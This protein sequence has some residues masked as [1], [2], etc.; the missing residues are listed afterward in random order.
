MR[1][2]ALVS[3]KGGVGKSTL[4]ACLAVE[5]AKAGY[6]V[7]V[8]DLDPQQSTAAWW[9][10]RKGPDN[11]LLATG[12]EAVSK[13]LRVIKAKKAGRDF[14]IADTP[15]SFIGVINDAIL[16]AD[17]VVIVSQ[18]SAKDLEAQGAVEGLIAKADKLHKTLYVI[19]RINPKSALTKQ[20]ADVLSAKSTRLPMM[21][22][23]RTDY[24]KADAAGKVA[25]E[26][27]KAAQA[28]ISALWNT[29]KEIA[30]D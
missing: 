24:V 11:P 28:E 22:C 21:V 19:N 20:A 7:Y 17:C 16:E 4:S 3:S 30:S 13:A 29:V 14:V 1:V 5:A 25:N 18:A 2:I 26:I 12:V 10:R 6:T 27:N 23:E 15:G 9:R 8:L